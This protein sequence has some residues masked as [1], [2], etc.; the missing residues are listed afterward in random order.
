MSQSRRYFLVN[1]LNGHFTKFEM[2]EFVIMHLFFILGPNIIVN[3]GYCVELWIENVELQFEEIE[4]LYKEHIYLLKVNSQNK[5][6]W[7]NLGTGQSHKNWIAIAMAIIKIVYLISPSRLSR[8]NQ[9]IDT[10][11]HCIFA[12]TIKP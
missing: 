6:K 9:K 7:L 2:Y 4:D 10:D 8:R 12:L 1:I 3:L 5:S 11:S